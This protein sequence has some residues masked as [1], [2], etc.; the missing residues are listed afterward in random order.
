MIDVRLLGPP[1]VEVD[2]TAVGF[3]TRKAVALLAFLA[4]SELPRPARPPGGPAVGRGHPARARRPAPHAV[5]DPGGR[6]R[7]PP[8]GRPQ[9]GRPAGAAPTSGST[10]GGSATRSRAGT[11]SWP[12][13]CTAG[14]SSRDSWSPGRRSSSSWQQATAETVR[15]EH[16]RAASSSR[17]TAGGGR[18]PAGGARGGPAL[19][20]PRRAA[21]ARTPDAD[22][23]DR[24]V[25]GQVGRADALSGLR[26]HP[27]P[28]AG[29]GT[30]GGDHCPLRGGA[31]R[32]A[33]R[34]R[35]RRRPR[36]FPCRTRP[37]PAGCDTAGRPRTRAGGAARGVPRGRQAR[38]GGGRRGR[39]GHRQDPRGRGDALAA[40]GRGSS[41]GRR[42]GLRGG[43]L[44]VLR[45]PRAG[46]AGPVAPGRGAGASS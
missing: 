4:M 38:A 20:G 10:S 42:P 6:G 43:V 24:D 9:H 32:D 37:G 28:R 46:A 33:A 35:P 41:D 26:A 11:S 27:R 25:R 31:Q 2:G 1:R 17:R 8:R 23:P 39:G 13:H 7:R 36:Q 14:S 29:C 44:T 30:A 15:A 5:D 22:P 16:G 40:R 12:R 21:R 34:C 45:A 3:D 19:A 18:R